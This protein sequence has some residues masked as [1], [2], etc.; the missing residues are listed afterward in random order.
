MK[1]ILVPYTGDEP[2]QAALE[3]AWY[4]ADAF[5]SYL[6]GLF[7]RRRPPVIAGEGITLP[8]D[9]VSQLVEETGRLAATAR[10]RFE[11]F[12][13]ARGAVL[14]DVTAPGPG[15]TAGWR[16]LEAAETGHVVGDHGR[17]FDLLVI[18]R[19]PGEEVGEWS[20]TCEAALFE[21]GRPVLVTGRAPDAAPGRNVTVAWNGSTETA[22]TL[23]MSMPVLL[24]AE[25]VEVL[26]VEG[27]TVPGPDASQ[28]ADHLRRNGVPASARSVESAGRSVGEA[29]LEEAKAA[30]ADLLVKGAYTHNRLRQMIFGGATR[31][32]LAAAEIPVLMAH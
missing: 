16:E 21:S 18:G 11:G 14:G 25:R 3:T 15:P 30:G 26:T 2:A 13:T 28:V 6:E 19:S 20:V 22:R 1:T 17:L 9:Y 32:I 31:H 23:S 5:E 7:V 10:E 24:R 27:G 4:L 12:V 8:G 29:I